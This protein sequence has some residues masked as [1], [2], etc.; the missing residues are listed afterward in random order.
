LGKKRRSVE[1]PRLTRGRA[2]ETTH[3]QDREQKKS[4]VSHASHSKHAQSHVSG[5]ISPFLQLILLPCRDRATTH[6]C[7]H[8]P[9]ITTNLKHF[10]FRVRH[11]TPL[12]PRCTDIPMSL[13][14]LLKN[15]CTSR[16][17]LSLGQCLNMFVL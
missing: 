4:A 6:V 5:P 12:C 9:A 13:K 3:Q 15:L 7:S 8:S 17:F 10:S 2:I 1:D 16:P 14:F 11:T